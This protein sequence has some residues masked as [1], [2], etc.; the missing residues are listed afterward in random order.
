MEDGSINHLP[1]IIEEVDVTPYLVFK[2]DGEDGPEVKGGYIDA[3]IIHASHVQKVT[4]NG[5]PMISWMHPK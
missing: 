4:D 2:K 1:N 5:K 3:L